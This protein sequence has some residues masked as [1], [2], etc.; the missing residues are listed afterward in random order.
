MTVEIPLNLI[1]FTL[2]ALIYLIVLHRRGQPWRE[3]FS[4]LGFQASPLVYYAWGLAIFA[5]VGILGVLATRSLPAEVLQNPNVSLSQYEG[6][7]LGVGTFFWLMLREAFYTTLGEE[8][9]F[10]G[11]LGGWLFQKLGFIMGNIVQ[12]LIFLLPHLLLLAVS[13]SL[14]PLL[15]VQFLAG[16]L[17]GWLRYRSNSIWPGWLA[18][19][20]TNTL[21]ALAFLA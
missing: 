21:A 11:F 5:V 9:F 16:W 1:L 17:L 3:A 13:L 4:K 6:M 14:W 20:L 8:I 2:P 10:R 19:W 7:A 18:H 12:A 15:P